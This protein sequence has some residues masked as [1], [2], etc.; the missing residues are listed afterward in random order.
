MLSPV[1]GVVSERAIVIRAGAYSERLVSFVSVL[2]QKSAMIGYGVWQDSR[3]RVEYAAIAYWPRAETA[4]IGVAHPG[5]PD[6]G[7]P[8][9]GRATW[10]A[11][12]ACKST[13]PEL[14]SWIAAHHHH[15]CRF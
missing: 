2:T 8:A 15:H 3:L 6:L 11:R 10:R 12:M 13:V 14:S 1:R 7:C 4:A 9:Q 5:N